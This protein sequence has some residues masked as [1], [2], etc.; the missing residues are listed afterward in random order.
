MTCHT[1]G[2]TGCIEHRC[3][4]DVYC[5]PCPNCDCGEIE[6]FVIPAAEFDDGLDDTDF[7]D[8][9]YG[10]FDSDPHDAEKFGF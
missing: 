4:D 9:D 6:E 2:G 10:P 8:D 5:E 3:G 1:C 7:E